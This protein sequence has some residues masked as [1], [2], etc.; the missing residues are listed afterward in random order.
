MVNLS[1]LVIKLSKHLK[2]VLDK[3]FKD[4]N[5]T[6]SQF[7]VLN[8]IYR[9]NREITSAEIAEQLSSDRPTISGVVNRL[10]KKRMIEKIENTEDKRSSYLKLSKDG[11]SL[12]KSLRETADKLNSEIF[13]A[14]DS[15]EIKKFEKYIDRLI[16]K[17][18]ENI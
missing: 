17:V 5:I 9:R 15:E 8:Q 2:N 3:E 7:S 6:A 12:I 1:Y 16:E 4:Y 18:E 13:T 11:E 14:L 10:E